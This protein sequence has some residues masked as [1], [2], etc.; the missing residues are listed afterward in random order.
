MRMGNIHHARY[1]MRAELLTLQHQTETEKN[2]VRSQV[3]PISKQNLT[4]L[5][6]WMDMFM[7]RVKEVRLIL[8]ASVNKS[9]P[10]FQIC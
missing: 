4:G 10:C 6:I 9:F 3:W 2:T 1:T 7:F 5:H 8:Y